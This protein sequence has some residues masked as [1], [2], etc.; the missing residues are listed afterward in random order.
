[1]DDPTSLTRVAIYD[2]RRLEDVGFVK[3]LSKTNV[4]NYFGATVVVHIT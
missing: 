3:Y 2:Y 4:Y 1:M